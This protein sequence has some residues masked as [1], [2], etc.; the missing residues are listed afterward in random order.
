MHHR[1]VRS[2]VP[3][4]PLDCILHNDALARHAS[5]PLGEDQLDRV[6]VLVIVLLCGGDGGVTAYERGGRGSPDHL[7][8]ARLLAIRL[9][10]RLAIP[11][12]ALL[13]LA[14]LGGVWPRSPAIDGGRVAASLCSRRK[15]RLTLPLAGARSQAAGGRSPARLGRFS[16]DFTELR[17][18][19]GWRH[20]GGGGDADL[21]IKL[22]PVGVV[23]DKEASDRKSTRLNSSH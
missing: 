10:L 14:L 1:H 8:A 22:V 19:G 6:L 13:R 21:G 12:L 15:V 17:I 2:L 9:G 11:R 3:L 20:I 16:R 18:G 4:V 23:C 5:L 7:L